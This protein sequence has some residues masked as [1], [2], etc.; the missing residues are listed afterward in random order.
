MQRL[1]RTRLRGGGAE[2]A[3]SFRSRSRFWKK[4]IPTVPLQQ[5]YLGMPSLSLPAIPPASQPKTG[6]CPDQASPA[7]RDDHRKRHMQGRPFLSFFLSNSHSLP[8]CLLLITFPP[9]S[10]PPPPL[11]SLAST[12]LAPASEG[13]SSSTNAVRTVN[14][15]VH[16]TIPLSS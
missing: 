10:P 7:G 5:G 14:E 16:C 12:P 6:N 13:D 11:P 2:K 8:F 3:F 15:R 9:V 4:R 1:F